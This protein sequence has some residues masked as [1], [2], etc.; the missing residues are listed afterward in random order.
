[1]VFP[2]ANPTFRLNGTRVWID[3]GTVGAEF[4]RGAP[5]PDLPE[6]MT[7]DDVTRLVLILAAR[8]AYGPVVTPDEVRANPGAFRTAVAAI[9][10]AVS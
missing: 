8:K 9:R 3:W 10:Q 5:L 6:G 4:E 7:A 2:T 1:M